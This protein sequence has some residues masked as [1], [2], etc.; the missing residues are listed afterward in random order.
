MHVP[1]WVLGLIGFAL[2]V[3]ACMILF[4]H[5]TRLN[6]GLAAVF[7]FVIAAVGAWIAVRGPADG[8]SGGLPFLP[9]EWNVRLGRAMFG[10]GAVI[11]AS[12]GVYALRRVM[13]RKL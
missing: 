8:F 10:A 12:I 2:L 1:Y 5:H 11:T 3:A 13:R 9:R 6:D 7:C 4:G